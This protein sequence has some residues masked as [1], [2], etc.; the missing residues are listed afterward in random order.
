MPATSGRPRLC[1]SSLNAAP[2]WTAMKTMCSKAGLWTENFTAPS[3]PTGSLKTMFLFRKRQPR[4]TRSAGAS[5]CLWERTGRGRV[6]AA[7]HN[8]KHEAKAQTESG[9][10]VKNPLAWPDFEGLLPESLL[11]DP[12]VKN[13]VENQ[14]RSTLTP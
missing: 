2:N 3:A 10:T 6:Q 1:E 14:K 12:S 5:P 8:R 11:N 9:V 7:A 4:T 13:W